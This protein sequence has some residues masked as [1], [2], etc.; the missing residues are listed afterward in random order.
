MPI[1]Q[2][3]AIVILIGLVLIGLWP[4]I[5]KAFLQE[6]T[7]PI[8]PS[9]SSGYA[10]EA[11]GVALVA[12]K[13]PSVGRSGS[14]LDRIAEC[15]SHNV[16]TAK[17]PH[18]TASGRFQFLKSSWEGYGKE[19]WGSLEGKDVFSFSDNTE[20]AE[21]VVSKYGTSP[22]NASRHCWE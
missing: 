13:L 4:L 11:P 2:N 8:H 20:L 7:P 12:L 1:K 16:A 6:E 15:E 18:S 10:L 5:A 14:I 21:Y 3:L 9:N 22:W 17:N 19:L